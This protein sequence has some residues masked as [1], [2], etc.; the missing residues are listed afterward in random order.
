MTLQKNTLPRKI[1]YQLSSPANEQSVYF[2]AG[3]SALL[4][5]LGWSSHF[6]R[7]SPLT[8]HAKTLAILGNR[9]LEAVDAARAA[10]RMPM[11]TIADTLEEREYIISLAGYAM[12]YHVCCVNS[13]IRF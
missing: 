12:F 2:M 5:V 6:F 9:Q 7:G 3:T 4:F 8:L 10:T 1:S 11:W 13:C